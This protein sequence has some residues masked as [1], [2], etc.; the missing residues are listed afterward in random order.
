M[1]QVLPHGAILHPWYEQPIIWLHTDS[2]CEPPLAHATLTAA[3][4]S[5][6]NEGKPAP[7]FCGLYEQEPVP[8]EHTVYVSPGV[9]E[10]IFL[11]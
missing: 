4:M 7:G 3:V 8:P 11:V 6:T 5:Y 1:P 2:P 9:A 10:I